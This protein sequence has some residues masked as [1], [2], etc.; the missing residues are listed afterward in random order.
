[1]KTICSQ[2]AFTLIEL[3]VVIAIIAILAGML[4]PAL[5]KAKEKANR[6]SC[7][8]NCKQMGLGSQMYAEDDSLH[9]LQGTLVPDKNGIPGGVGGGVGAQQADDDMNWLHGFGPGFPSYISS[10]KTFTC[11][12]TKN[13]VDI[14]QWSYVLF[15]GQTIRVLKNLSDKA[16]N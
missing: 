2:K 4:L 14:N 16:M 10:V 12:S 9:R 3:L 6:I 5:A 13:T 8:N 1:M 11:P 7:L 15:N